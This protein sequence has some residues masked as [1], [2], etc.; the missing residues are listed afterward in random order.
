MSTGCTVCAS[1]PTN[2]MISQGD[3]LARLLLRINSLERISPAR[4]RLGRGG[5]GHEQGSQ[6]SDGFGEWRA[7]V[8]MLDALPG[9]SGRRSVGADRAC[10]TACFV[11]ACRERNVT[12]HV[13]S[14]DTRVGGSAI[15]GRT[16]TD[17]RA[18]G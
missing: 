16:T 10:A 3:H 11:G 1:C 4:G 6:S 8:A 18:I 15:D 7:A 13:A 12:P 17:I 14:N 5:S 9:T 2:L